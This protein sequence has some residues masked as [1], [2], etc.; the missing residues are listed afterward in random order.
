MVS[1]RTPRTCPKLTEVI[2]LI[3]FLGVIW[4]LSYPRKCWAA[5]LLLG[6]S[7]QWPCCGLSVLAGMPFPTGEVSCQVRGHFCP[8]VSKKGQCCASRH[9]QQGGTLA[10]GHYPRLMVTF[11]QEWGVVRRFLLAFQN[12]LSCPQIQA[13]AGSAH[14]AFL[15]TFFVYYSDSVR[16]N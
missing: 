15:F 10:G 9:S 16:F 3:G 14:S 11:P 1:V 6:P 12:V 7:R 5:L 4:K 2:G 8:Y 13:L